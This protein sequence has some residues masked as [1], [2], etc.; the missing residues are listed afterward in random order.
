MR[1]VVLLAF[2]TVA[3]PIVVLG[4][5]V[6]QEKA[7]YKAMPGDAPV[8][9]RAAQQTLIGSQIQIDVKVIEVSLTKMRALGIEVQSFD[10]GQLDKAVAS[11]GDDKATVE[12]QTPRTDNAK[13]VAAFF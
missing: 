7:V 13:H 9:P 6:P 10:Q 8:A 3:L 12:N 2:F 5:D 4:Q 11:L 1:L